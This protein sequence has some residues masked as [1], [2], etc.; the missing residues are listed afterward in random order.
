M[1]KVINRCQIF[2]LTQVFA[3]DAGRR[4]WVKQL[5]VLLWITS[6]TFCASLVQFVVRVI[7]LKIILL[8][9]SWFVLFFIFLDKPLQGKAFYTVDSKPHCDDCYMVNWKK[10]LLVIYWTELIERWVMVFVGDAGEML[11]MHETDSWSDFEGYWQA[12]PRE[13]SVLRRLWE[14]SRR[15]S[16]HCWCSQSHPLRRSTSTFSWN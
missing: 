10:C 15:D 4:S 2:H 6:I 9:H 1:D 16:F 14:M 12:V 3:S 5:D 11:G 8:K 7:S 13:V